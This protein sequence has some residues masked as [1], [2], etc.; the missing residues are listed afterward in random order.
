[1]KKRGLC[2]NNPLLFALNIVTLVTITK[3]GAHGFSMAGHTNSF[4]NRKTRLD[5][6]MA[7]WL[8]GW[9]AK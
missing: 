7:G 9:I 4:L 1:M 5:G 6:W 2:A 3:G 8:D